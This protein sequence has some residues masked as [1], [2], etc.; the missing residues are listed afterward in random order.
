MKRTLTIVF[1]ISLMIEVFGQKFWISGSQYDSIPYQTL[2]EDQLYQIDGVYQ[3]GESEW[4]STIL[5]IRSEIGVVVQL[6]NSEWI[7]N[8]SGQVIGAKTKIKTYDDVV[9][10]SGHL[11]TQDFE[12]EFVKLI[13]HQNTKIALLSCA[14][15]IDLIEE[16]EFGIQVASDLIELFPGNYPEA[17]ARLLR[18]NELRKYSAAELRLMRNEIFARYGYDFESGGEMEAAFEGEDWYSKSDADI[19]S[20][21]TIIEETNIK[22]IK[23]IE[24]KR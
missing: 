19:T 13:D 12:A 11:K 18:A 2:D 21:L 5:I 16:N 23:K 1:F 3:F 8:E 9:L 6:R 22:T 20:F 15:E 10:N 7:E 17:S 4:E 24:N 14:S